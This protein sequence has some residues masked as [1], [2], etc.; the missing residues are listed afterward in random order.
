MRPA[1]AAPAPSTPAAPDDIPYS[2]LG[3]IGLLYVSPADR[4]SAM[5][6]AARQQQLDVAANAEKAAEAQRARKKAEARELVASGAAAATGEAAAAAAV[7]LRPSKR[8]KA[9]KLRQCK[10]S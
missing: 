8:S 10:S 1:P 5:S 7:D 4:L 6:H 2:T 3:D 9:R